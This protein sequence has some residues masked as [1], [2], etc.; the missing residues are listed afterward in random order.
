MTFEERL[1]GGEVL[2]D[3][4]VWGR[5]VAGSLPGQVE[6]K[7][8]RTQDGSISGVFKESKASRAGIR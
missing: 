3:M 6:S 5:G 2:E 7:V 1:P 4:E 8:Q